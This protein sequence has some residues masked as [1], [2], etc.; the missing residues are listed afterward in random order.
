MAS[1]TPDARPPDLRGLDPARLVDVLDP[2]EAIAPELP[3]WKILGI[4]GQGG[5]GIV[6]RAEDEA[7]ERLAAIKIADGNDPDTV[8][9]IEQEAESLRNLRH[10]NIVALLDSGTFEDGAESLEGGVFVAM[11]FIEGSPLS[12]VIPHGGLAPERA[13]DLFRKIGA[14]VSYAHSCG[15]LIAI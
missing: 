13:F 2:V 7:G 9:R 5:F 6:W 15:I 4:A 10:P 1:D 12:E 11:E 3:G 14:A 8:E